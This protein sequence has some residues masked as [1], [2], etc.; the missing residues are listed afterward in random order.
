MEM[1]NEN[2]QISVA[3]SADNFNNFFNGLAKQLGVKRYSKE[4]NRYLWVNILGVS[5][6]VYDK[7]NNR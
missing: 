6:D 1:K 2:G 7:I 3:T 5:P 4:Y